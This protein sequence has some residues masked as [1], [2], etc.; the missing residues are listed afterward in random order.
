[1][2]KIVDRFRLMNRNE[3]D[4]FEMF[5]IPKGDEICLVNTQKTPKEILCM[6]HQEFDC[7]RDGI[8]ER[9]VLDIL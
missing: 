3:V 4:H 6:R 1:M 8:F 5:S 9:E 7:Q 2:K